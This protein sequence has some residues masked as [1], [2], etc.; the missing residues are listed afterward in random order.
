MISAPKPD[1]RRIATS[2]S[3]TAHRVRWELL[4]GVA[5]VLAAVLVP[6]TARAYAAAGSGQ[7]EG[8]VCAGGSTAD[9]YSPPRA[10]IPTNPSFVLTAQDGYITTP[11]G[12][13]IYMWGY[14][15]GS[16][17]YQDPGPVLCVN[18]GDQVTITLKNTLPVAT[19]IQFPGL[20]GVLA[21]GAPTQPQAA[22]ASLATPVPA[23]AGS[24]PNYIDPN[25]I[26]SVTYSF[27]ADHPG[28]FLYESGTDPALQVQMGLVGALVVRPK[29]GNPCFSGTPAAGTVC[30]PSS[31][32]Y[33]DRDGNRSG[34]LRST[35]RRPG[36]F[37]DLQSQKGVPA[38][39]QRDRPH[40][41][42]SDRGHDRRQRLLL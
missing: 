7:R 13:S 26:G 33:D 34:Q 30:T 5:I 19:S 37:L 15:S 27:T 9:F 32:V 25:G 8:L 38:P 6:I 16:G 10:P 2:L 21:E 18:E 40:A 31:H 17:A 1:P 29:V 24:R 12:N 20:T 36:L 42:R 39:A 22:T 14:A 23:D 4:A 28:T 41:P 3:R 35:G 11:D